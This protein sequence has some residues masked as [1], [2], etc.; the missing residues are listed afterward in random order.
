MD[1]HSNGRPQLI[2]RESRDESAPRRSLRA[3]RHFN[4]LKRRPRPPSAN[5]SRDELA[6]NPSQPCPHLPRRPAAQSSGPA[7]RTNP[8][9]RKAQRRGLGAQRLGSAERQRRS[10]T[11]S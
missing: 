4:R 9:P 3:E 11:Q 2:P 10:P 6:T 8:P 1:A 5:S 7:R